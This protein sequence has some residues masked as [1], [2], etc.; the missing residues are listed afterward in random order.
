MGCLDYLEKEFWSCAFLYA[1]CNFYNR[2]VINQRKKSAAARCSWSSGRLEKH[3]MLQVQDRD[4]QRRLHRLNIPR[5]SSQ[6]INSPPTP[7]T[8]LT[9]PAS[10]GSFPEAS[11]PSQSFFSPTSGIRLLR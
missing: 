2:V 5:L 1:I 11:P 3:S 7:S 6:M 4:L 9:S 8:N 10:Q